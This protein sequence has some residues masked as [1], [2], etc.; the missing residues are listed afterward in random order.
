L[1]EQE[2][3]LA[4]GLSHALAQQ[5]QIG[6]WSHVFHCTSAVA[7]GLR[8]VPWHVAGGVVGHRRKRPKQFGGVDRQ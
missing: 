7:D 6:R 2:V 1:V 5:H 3:A 8:I 4:L